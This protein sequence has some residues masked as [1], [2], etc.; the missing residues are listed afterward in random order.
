[1]KEPGQMNPREIKI[2]GLV[3]RYLA[4]RPDASLRETAHPDQDMLAAFTEGSLS[5]REAAPLVTH[6]VDCSFCRHISA[7][8]VR[9]D[10]G[11]AEEPRSTATLSTA[12]EPARI[13]E[14]LSNL[15]AKIFGTSDGAV[16][17][18][19]EKEEE[20]EIDSENEKDN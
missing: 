6:L 3:D 2:Q 9:L 13:S 19:Q 15:F 20:P 10:L 14:V 4:T 5:E 18:H 12:G 7:E 8:L 11:L 16:F 1:M 17:A